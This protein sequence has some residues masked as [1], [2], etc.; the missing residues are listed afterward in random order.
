MSEDDTV[1]L[2]DLNTLQTPNT[3]DIQPKAVLHAHPGVVT[4]LDFSPDG[5]MLVN[6]SEGGILRLWNT[7]TA[8][9]QG[10][11]FTGHEYWIRAAAFLPDGIAYIN[12]VSLKARFISGMQLV[13]HRHS[14]RCQIS[15][16][17]RRFLQTV[18]PLRVRMETIRFFCGI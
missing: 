13:V 12:R 15:S 16:V 6:G 17:Q 14:S 18:E 1:R 9:Q 10:P 2:W 7:E 5:S 11:L 3:V 8:Q 4:A